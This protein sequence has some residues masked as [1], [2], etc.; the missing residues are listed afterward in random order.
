MSP[1]EISQSA[2]K[3]M[4]RLAIKPV[5]VNIVKDILNT[6]LAPPK[7]CKANRSAVKIEMAI[8]TPALEIC[9]SNK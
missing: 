1:L 6:L 5:M 7:S 8:G 9:N 2:P 4:A 3:Y